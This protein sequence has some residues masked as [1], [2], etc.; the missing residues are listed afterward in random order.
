MEFSEQ[1]VTLF[2]MPHENHAGV[3]KAY[4]YH[5]KSKTFIPQKATCKEMKQHSGA[6]TMVDINDIQFDANRCLC[7][8][9]HRLEEQDK[10]AQQWVK[11]MKKKASM[12]LSAG[13]HKLMDMRGG[14][15][16]DNSEDDSNSGSEEDSENEDGQ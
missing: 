7:K 16:K 9:E 14:S 10:R 1:Q 11:K 2:H 6:F 12:F 13:K 4:N 5:Y 8:R 15:N 3:G